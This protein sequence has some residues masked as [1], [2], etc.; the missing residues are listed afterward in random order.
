[1][2]DQ[3]MMNLLKVLTNQARLAEVSNRKVRERWQSGKL[4]IMDSSIMDFSRG[5]EYAK[6]MN[7]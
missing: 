3:T 4:R 7:A 1:M 2:V 6:M 5:I